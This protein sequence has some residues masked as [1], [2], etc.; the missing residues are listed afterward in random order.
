MQQFKIKFSAIEIRHLL[1]AWLVISIAFSIAFGIS[2]FVSMFTVGLGFIAHELSHKAV[3]QRFKCFAEFRADFGMLLLAIIF[4][5]MGFVFA[6][7]GAVVIL[8]RVRKDQYGKISLAGPLANIILALLFFFLAL[9]P[10]S[11]LKTIAVY[12][13]QINSWLA[14]FNLIPFGPLDGRKILFWNK[15]IFAL[16]LIT[17]LLLVFGMPSLLSNLALG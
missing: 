12:G 3:A 15:K 9:N 16:V 2:I 17:A 1:I 8:G 14:L 6:A 4:A 5:F 10:A 7:P 13:F 11:F